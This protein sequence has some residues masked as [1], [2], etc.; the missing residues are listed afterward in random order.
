[1][2][3]RINRKVPGHIVRLTGLV[4]FPVEQRSGSAVKSAFDSCSLIK[5]KISNL[6]LSA[7][8]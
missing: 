5:K 8:S 6:A 4:S 1:M 2:E 7:G 3:L